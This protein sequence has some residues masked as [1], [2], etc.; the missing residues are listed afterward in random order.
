MSAYRWLKARFR[1]FRQSYWAPFT[2]ILAVLA[3]AVFIQRQFQKNEFRK[4]ER[5]G[6]PVRAARNPLPDSLKRSLTSFLNEAGLTPKVAAGKS[7][8]RWAVDVPAHIPIPTLHQQIQDRVSDS[9]GT[10]V[11][12]V[13]DPV[14][15]RVELR[16]GAG[17]STFLVLTL[18]RPKVE[19]TE[20]G[21]IAVVI[22]DFGD[23][24]DAMVE[25]FLS[26][27]APITFS[28]LPGRKYSA[29]I[30]GESIQKGHEVIL[31]LIMEPL[32]EPFKDDG[33]VVLK[34]MPPSQ[35]REIV[36]RSLKE[37][38]GAIGVNNHMGSKATQDR[39]TMVPVFQLLGE[40]GL[41]FM[42]SYTIASSVA[43]PL[44]REMGLRTARRDV[45]LD[46]TNGEAAIRQKLRDLARK[47]GKNGSAIGI[48][49]CHR[50]MLR[51]LQAEIPEI[52]AEGFRFVQLS[53]LVR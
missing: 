4:V 27:D 42:D 17:D 34:G 2:L 39:P 41:F 36:E 47:A 10:I 38:P 40:R 28:V 15:G 26:L 3:A 52:Q 32:N 5:A 6:T 48:G 16:V 33:N 13:S 53:E 11:S 30:A 7:V 22:D 8:E 19:K 43:F 51:A 9:G 29:R 49:H 50:D 35:I 23:K 44:A 37:V 24:R 12:A 31:H 45:F 14:S 25:A 1:L 20:A 18:G 21:R 46:V